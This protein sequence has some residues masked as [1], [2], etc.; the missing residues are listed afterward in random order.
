MEPPEVFLKDLCDYYGVSM[1]DAVKLGTRSSGRKPNLPGSKTCDPV[2]D[3]TLE[4]IWAV[5]KRIDENS[6][7]K[8]YKDQGAWSSFRQVVRHL[9][10]INDHI[11]ILNAFQIMPGMHICEYGC[12]VAPFM[13]T[14]LQYADKNIRN[15]EI[16]LSDVDSE[17]FSFGAWRIRK[18]IAERDININLNAVEI[19]PGKLPVYNTLLDIVI[20]FEVL[21]HVPSPVKCIENLTGQ[22][23]VNGILLENF[24]KHGAEDDDDGPDLKS[25]RTEREVYYQFLKQNFDLVGGRSE[26]IEPNATRIWRKRMVI[27]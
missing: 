25:A 23:S 16:S 6:I 13:R 26:D 11:D 14:F 22:M 17:H 18:T 9:D 4:D 5:S 1:Q 21:E 8:F 3:M 7:F 15:I 12:G 10:L 20:I 27:K 2:S 19:E 24:I